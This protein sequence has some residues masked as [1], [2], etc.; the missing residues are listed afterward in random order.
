MLIAKTSSERRFARHVAVLA[1][2]TPIAHLLTIGTLPLIVRL[3][4]PE[5]FGVLRVF[6]AV[7]SI[8]RSP[9]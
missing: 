6:V 7:P 2:G 9:T 4:T 1:G 3:N 5:Q 8:I